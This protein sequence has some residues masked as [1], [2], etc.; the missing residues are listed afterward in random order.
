M[1][2]IAHT[3]TTRASLP[4]PTMSQELS[5]SSHPST[6]RQRI[7]RTSK[8]QMPSPDNQSPA[9]CEFFPKA[10]LGSHP[11]PPCLQAMEMTA[12]RSTR[13][14]LS[15]PFPSRANSSFAARILAQAAPDRAA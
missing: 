3:P 5:E 12:N 10:P 13:D 9:Q 8:R 11:A 14:S 7:L 15:Q 6:A 1:A 2:R 4:A